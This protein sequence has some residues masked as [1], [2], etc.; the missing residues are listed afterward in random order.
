MAGLFEKPPGHVHPRGY[1]VLITNKDFR[2]INLPILAYPGKKV[3]DPTRR[4]ADE[5]DT[6][7]QYVFDTKLRFQ[8]LDNRTYKNVYKYPYE[9]FDVP[10]WIHNKPSEQAP[11]INQAQ[12]KCL[13]CRIQM[14]DHSKTDCFVLAISTHGVQ[15]D[16]EQEI[17]FSDE[18]LADRVTLSDVIETL[19]DENCPTLRGKPRIIILNLC[20]SDPDVPKG[21][22]D[23]VWHD[24]GHTYNIAEQDDLSKPLQNLTLCGGGD[25]T[26]ERS[27]KQS[28][29]G[30]DFKCQE[31]TKEIEH[32]GVEKC[33]DEDEKNKINE[34]YYYGTEKALRNLP[35]NFLIVFPTVSGKKT[36][37]NFKYGSWLIDELR[38]VVE[39]HDFDKNPCMNFLSVL[40]TTAGRV[41]RDKE[42][43]EGYKTAVCIVHRLLQP[44]IFTDAK[45]K[46]DEKPD[47]NEDKPASLF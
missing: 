17:C 28:G 9:T 47:L 4:G 34:E 37:H 38:K 45:G 42:S 39:E 2:W 24:K 7:L 21:K 12:C 30:N 11:P 10:F 19:S 46:E 26:K 18:Y 35:S 31:E 25:N 27:E 6:N 13:S 43:K 36:F 44:L 22:Q 40:T 16:G 1:A 29:C 20:R 15:V 32:K 41:A 8:L 33:E 5:D 14:T 3:S 23:E